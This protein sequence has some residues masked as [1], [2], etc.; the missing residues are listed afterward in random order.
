MV[1]TCVDKVGTPSRS[2]F[3]PLVWCLLVHRQSP[4]MLPSETSA[5]STKRSLSVAKNLLKKAHQERQSQSRQK[6]VEAAQQQMGEVK[7]KPQPD[8]ATAKAFTSQA[9]EPQFIWDEEGKTRI[10]LPPGARGGEFFPLTKTTIWE[11]G[12]FGPGI[13][14]LFHTIRG[15]GTAMMICGVRPSL[16]HPPPQ[17]NNRF[18]SEGRPLPRGAVLLQR[19]V[20]AGSV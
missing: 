4:A 19:A 15:L 18:F 5:P 1:R 17:L 2:T 13:G 7:E 3:H 10:L 6:L 8:L 14:L 16:L 11:L 9:I 12:A 20:L